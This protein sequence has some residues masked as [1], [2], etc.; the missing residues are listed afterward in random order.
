MK[1]PVSARLP[2]LE[3]RLL[4]QEQKESQGLLTWEFSCSTLVPAGAGRPTLPQELKPA[5]PTSACRSCSVCD[6]A[7]YLQ[8]YLRSR[9][10]SRST[11][12]IQL[13]TDSCG[14][15]AHSA[16]T[17]VADQSFFDDFR[18]HA[19]SVVPD[20]QPQYLVAIVDFRFDPAR[21]RV[22]EG[23]SYRLAGNP[24][25]FILEDRLEVAWPTFH[26]N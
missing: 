23:I 20:T 1:L 22:A 19:P 18:I 5:P 12:D 6:R 15:F 13:P 17:V 10:R 8:L 2:S 4:W 3:F 14:A 9:S 24:V 25:D 26:L 7:G 11:P 16:Q 21:L